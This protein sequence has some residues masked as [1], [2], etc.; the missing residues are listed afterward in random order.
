MMSAWSVLQSF[1]LHHIL[2]LGIWREDVEAGK[3]AYSEAT[4]VEAVGE[5]RLSMVESDHLE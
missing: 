1:V 3:V 5:Y 4:H 2:G